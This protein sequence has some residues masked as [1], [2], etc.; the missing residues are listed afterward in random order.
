MTELTLVQ[1]EESTGPSREMESLTRMVLRR[2]L[3]HKMALI[4]LM[5]LALVILSAVLAPLSPYSPTEQN[6]KNSLQ[7]PS[8]D[9]WFGTDDLGRDVF[10][11]TLYG[12]R[13]S[14][15]VGLLATVLA[16]SLGVIVGALSG[17]F[18]GMTDGVLMRLTDAFLSLP[19]LFVLILVSTLLRDMPALK[20]RNSVSV[21]VIVI[22][23]LAWMWPARLVRG[24]FLK[25]KAQEF[26]QAAICVGVGDARIITRHI[27]PNS[28]SVIIVQG[29]LL[30][31]YA[32]IIE[33]G[34]SYLGFG[35]QPPTPSWGNQLA[36]AQVYAL[37]AP[38]LM[39]FP[40]L[41]IFATAMAVNHIGD[42]LRD[43]FDPFAV[44]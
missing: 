34:L 9:H 20:L 32:I 23:V 21:V 4:S 6:P 15:S 36:T 44:R 8:L 40:G 25:L 42:G 38:W 13:I 41:M 27:L 30:I 24:E 28:V 1:A 37:R 10:T 26:V 43:A 39:I 3:R 2:F 33:S 14:I 17:Y 5:V 12:G 31:A 22:A 7:P 35:V 16:I 11:R 18:G 29:T 19:S